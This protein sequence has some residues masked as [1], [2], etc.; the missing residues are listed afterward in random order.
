MDASVVSHLRCPA[1]RQPLSAGDRTVHCPDG[2][3]YDLARQGYVDL[4][5]G[6]VTHDGDTAPMVAARTGLLRAGH[7]AVVTSGVIDAVTAVTASAP[8]CAGPGLIVDVGAGTGHHLAGVLDAAPDLV[9]L[10]VD[11]SKAALRRAARAHQRLA[12]VRADIWRGLPV[13]TGAAS[14]LLDIFAPRSGPEFHRLLRP[15]GTLIVVTPGRGHLAELVDG[16]GLLTVDPDKQE[17]LRTGLGPWFDR[18]DHRELT[19]RLR[20]SAADAAA[21]VMMGPNAHHVGPEVL[22][23]RLAGHP[24]P[25]TVTVAVSIDVLHPR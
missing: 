10:A 12:A 15:G 4:S 6:R 14:V 19:T 21:M 1:C 13:A 7:L 18:S 2:H 9:G 24:G 17:R 20:L 22:A 5:G 16:L 3:S 8:A 23:E 25:A 11:V